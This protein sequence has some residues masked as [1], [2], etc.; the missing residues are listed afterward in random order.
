MRDNNKIAAKNFHG[1]LFP[2]AFSLHY[3]GFRNMIMAVFFV[4]GNSK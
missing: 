4:A 2:C 3:R 1:P